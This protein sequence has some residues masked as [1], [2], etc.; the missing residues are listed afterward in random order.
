MR[1]KVNKYKYEW[2][3]NELNEEFWN[4]VLL[5]RTITQVNFDETGIKS[6]FLDSG[7]EVSL[8]RDGHVKSILYIKHP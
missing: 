4:E 8:L 1:T 2:K 3:E 6:L 7:E 5:H